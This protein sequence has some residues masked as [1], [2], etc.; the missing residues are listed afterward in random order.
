M[1]LAR[2]ALLRMIIIPRIRYDMAAMR[3]SNNWRRGANAHQ[4]ACSYPNAFAVIRRP[5]LPA[6]VI[7]ITTGYRSN[8]FSFI[9][10]GVTGPDA[11]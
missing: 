3:Y 11:G 4:R 8:F 6:T 7:F 9:L 10:Y 5:P 1:E 2:T